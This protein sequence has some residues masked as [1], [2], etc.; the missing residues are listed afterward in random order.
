M[1]AWTI[2]LHEHC[3]TRKVSNVELNHEYRVKL[4]KYMYAF[5][6]EYTSVGLAHTHPIRAGLPFKEHNIAKW[7]WSWRRYGTTYIKLFE[8]QLNFHASKLQIN[9]YPLC[10]LLQCT[11]EGRIF[12]LKVECGEKYPDEP[13][14]VKFTTRINLPGINAG[15]GEVQIK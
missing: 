13:P 6:I 3:G 12:Q 7:V 10:L 14:K 2:I 15:T 4:S 1:H 9:L 11:C 8:Q 5:S